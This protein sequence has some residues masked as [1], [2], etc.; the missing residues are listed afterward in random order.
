VIASGRARRLCLRAGLWLLAAFCWASCPALAA[1]STPTATT[2]DLEAAQRLL[3]SARA[4]LPSQWAAS[5]P[6]DLAVQWRDDLPRHVAGRTFGTRLRLDRKLLDAWRE[7]QADPWLD[8]AAR[9]GLATVIHELAHVLDR[10][11]GS[12]LSRDPRLRDLAGWPRRRYWPGRGGNALRERSPDRYELADAREFLAVNLEHY[13]LDPDYA[14]RR[15]ALAAWLQARV[16]TP[17][18]RQTA[19]DPALPLLQAE[20]ADGQAGW[21]A[22]DPARVYAI[23]Y[24]FAEG[25]DAPMSRWGHAMLRLV[26]CAPGRAPGPD[27][28]LDL[29]W[30][31]VLSFRAFVNDVQISSWRGLT[32]AYPSRL[33]VLP[34]EQVID[35]YTQVE[36]RGLASYPLAL[37]R[38]A[39]AAVLERAAQLHWSYDG[40]YAFISNNCAVETWK[41]LR[42]AD[43]RIGE[44]AHWRGITPSG[45]LAALERAGLAYGSKLADL[46]NA[47][48]EGYYFASAA[49]HYQQ[50]FAVANAQ[51]A[52]PAASAQAW[53]DLP[54][55]T[56]APWIVR[57]DLRAT[58]A[59]LLLEQAAQRRQELRARDWL[60]RR[61]S[62]DDGAADHARGQVR[63]LLQDAGALA[64]P[65]ALLAGVPGYGLPQSAERDAVEQRLPAHNQRLASGWPTL[66]AQARAALPE[67]QREEWRRI[68]ENLLVI[69]RRLRE[70]AAT[71]TRQRVPPQS[72]PT[73]L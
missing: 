31:R 28:R 21:L 46:A 16:G 32:G 72:L 51:A 34:L 27:C 58:A 1:A 63:E 4:S 59:F 45:L 18:L 66:R 42:D 49:Q 41:L 62:Q 11:Q 67:A 52:L 7:P 5:L 47:Q 71:E 43:P 3:S 33:Y 53:L 64:A 61:L 14:C 44:R 9:L 56:R 23:D 38:Q 2:V 73:T 70:L 57:G 17:P 13:V 20:H 60:K 69:Q 26:I 55:A 24:L 39:I 15:P 68:D 10:Q 30:H 12:A 36:L 54:A 25:N 6:T 40:R 8:P 50:M 48:R 65:A 22:L 19:C 35:D 37:D 29:A